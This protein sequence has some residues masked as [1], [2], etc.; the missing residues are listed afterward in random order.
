MAPGDI[1]AE[2]VSMDRRREGGVGCRSQPPDLGRV[3]VVVQRGAAPGWI[4]QP[5]PGQRNTLLD[6]EGDDG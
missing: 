6:E 5:A 3:S 2:T 4:S 1:E